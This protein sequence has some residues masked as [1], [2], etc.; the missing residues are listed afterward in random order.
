MKKLKPFGIELKTDPMIIKKDLL[1]EKLA[2][3]KLVLFKNRFLDKTDLIRFG[4]GLGELLEWSF[5]KVMELKPSQDPK[6]YLFSHE[7]VPF[8]WDGAFHREPKLLIFNCL[9]APKAKSGGETLFTDLEALYSNASE[10]AR[11]RWNNIELTYKTEKLAHYG[12][13]ITLPMVQ[14]GR[15]MRYAEPVKTSLNPV[16]L[17]VKGIDHVNDFIE[18]MK[19][20][21]YDPAHCLA[22]VWQPGDLLIACNQRLVHGRR[23]FTKKSDRLIRRVQVL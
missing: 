4:E 5:G 16:S 3:H 2:K 1:A 19:Q 17:Q 22:H 20:R 14:E 15:A 13:E 10:E 11:Q 7:A 21:L 12:G 9:E 23:A 18:D 8:H 6:N